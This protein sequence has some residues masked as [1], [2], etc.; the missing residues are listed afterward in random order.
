MKKTPVALITGASEGLGKHLALECARRHMN[1]VLVALPDSH[2]QSLARYISY[3]YGVHVWAFEKDLCAEASC[4]ELYEAVK[5]EGITISILINN[6][7]MGGTF[8]FGQRSTEYYNTLIRLNVVAAT[9]LTRLFLDDLKAEAPSFIL[10]VSSLAGILHPP[11]KGV[12]GGT[13]AFLLAF[14]KSLRRELKED[15]I[16]VSVLCPGSMNTTWQL[17]L[18]NRIMDSWIARQSVLY[19]CVVARMAIAKMLAGKGVIVPGRWNRCFLVWNSFFPNRIK[20]LL[21]AYVMRKAS[22]VVPGTAA[23][24][25]VRQTA[26]VA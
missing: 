5:A 10:N 25:P 9:L 1:L 8:F 16:S 4:A 15:K 13:K 2:L 12:Y 17:M 20:D 23:I 18:Q 6:A 26:A 24:E 11:K 3:N 19:P 21:S 7:G 22:P 14:S